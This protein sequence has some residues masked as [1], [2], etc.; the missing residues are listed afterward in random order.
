MTMTDPDDGLA[1]C[2]ICGAPV[3]LVT[4][5]RRRARQFER[6][7]AEAWGSDIPVR[8][9]QCTV[10]KSHRLASLH[11]SRARPVNF[12]VIWPTLV[13]LNDSLFEHRCRAMTLIR[14]RHCR[15][16][17]VVAAST[18]SNSAK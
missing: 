6:D 11:Q 1:P 4:V 9:F 14:I 2:D 5:G 16:G 15:S 17:R 18:A 7:I 3:E 8:E 12:R 13:A 10:D